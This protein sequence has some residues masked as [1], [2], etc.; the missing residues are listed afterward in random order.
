MSWEISKLITVLYKSEQI[1]DY[2]RIAI[3]PKCHQR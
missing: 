2:Y 3:I 1:G